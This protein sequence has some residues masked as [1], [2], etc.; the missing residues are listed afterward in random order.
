M[1]LESVESV[2]H[3]LPNNPL[4]SYFQNGWELMLKTYS[5]WQICTFGSLFVHEILYFAICLPAFLFQF[6]PF[7]QRFKIQQNIIETKEAQMKCFKLLLFN[8][9]CIQFP[10]IMGTYYFVEFLNIPLEYEK[11]PRWY[12]IGLQVIGCAIIEDTWHYF[13][14]R[15]MHHRKLYKYVHK[16]H[17]TFNAPFGM[18]AEYAHPVETLVLGMGFFIGILTFTTHMILLWIWVLFR[19]LE[20]IDVHSGY[21]IWFLNPF[22]LLPGYAGVRFHDFHHMNF[23][24]NYSSTFVWWDKLF[25]TDSQYNRFKEKQRLQSSNKDYD[26]CSQNFTSNA[27]NGRVESGYFK[28]DCTRKGL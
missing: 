10:L 8:H 1:S 20:T 17:H 14:H 28:G 25:G 22:H 15:M 7:M 2:L 21:D 4:A 18:V 23:V 26:E 3:Y 6:I 13:L 9:I 12:I 27:N 16:L 24:G 19:L 5:K 11:M